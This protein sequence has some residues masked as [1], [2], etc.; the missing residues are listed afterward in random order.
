MRTLVYFI[1]LRTCALFPLNE[2]KVFIDNFNGKGFSGNSKYVALELLKR[3]SGYQIVWVVNSD[4][5]LKEFPKAIKTVK[6][7]SF[8]AAYEIETSR[9]WIDNVRKNGFYKRKKQIYIQVWHGLIGIKLVEGQVS[10]KLSENYCKIARLDSQATDVL[11]APCK[12]YEL[13]MKKFF[14]IAPEKVK[15][16]GAPEFDALYKKDFSKKKRDIRISLGVDNKKILLYA[17]TFRSNN[18]YDYFSIDFSK[19][20]STLTLKFGGE[21]VLAI[22]MHPNIGSVNHKTIKCPVID[23][24]KYDDCQDLIIVSD[25]LITDYSSIVFNSAIIHVPSFIHATDLKEY[26]NER[27]F[28][29]PFESLPFPISQTDDELLSNIIDYSVEKYNPRY[30]SFLSD[31]GVLFDD[32]ASKRVV[33]IMES[34]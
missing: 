29:L 23:V 9:Y 2:R 13:I 3:N 33:D 31:I 19:V 34:F 22:R 15:Y 18:K 10:D 25:A 4:V 6:A 32:K 24:T 28:E 26:M 14:W 12:R 7:R 30:D 5:N 21:W 11:V 27:D 17:P 20:L 1:A 16:L 8:R